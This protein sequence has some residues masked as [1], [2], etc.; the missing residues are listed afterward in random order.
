M[1]YT[2]RQIQC[3][4][5]L[6]EQLHFGRAAIR[7]NITQPA[8]SRQIAALE[9][10]LQVQLV[11]RCTG[12]V[13]LT[14][15]GE[16]FLAGCSEVSNILEVAERRA[17]RVAAGAEGT[18][19]VGYTDFAIS[20]KLPDLFAA[21][22][23]TYPAVVMEPFQSST[24]DLLSRL[25]QDQLDVV[26]A[27]GPIDRIGIAVSPFTKNRLIGI[28]YAQHA[29]A[30][31]KVLRL[32]DFDGE[33]LVLGLER[34]WSHF[35]SHLEPALAKAPI[36][37]R[38]A[39]RGYNSEGLFGLVASQAGITIYPDCARNYVR[40]GLVLREIEDLTDAVPTEIA[41]RNAHSSSAARTFVAFARAA[42]A[43]V[44]AVSV[45]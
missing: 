13:H 24:A 34:F 1:K 19:R 37:Y 23:Q 28:L 3:F 21:F 45:A 31:K 14:P 20:S 29:L 25:E 2:L 41:W 11:V 17:R 18:V 6:S 35:L 15:A 38:V 22:R 10:A 36:C 44:A 42:S 27:T 32:A 39:E 30:R 5:A 7:A 8:L 33:D 16:A 43:D 12:D 9:D 40:K 4:L 26:F